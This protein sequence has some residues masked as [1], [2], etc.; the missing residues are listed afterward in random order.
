MVTS[1]EDAVKFLETAETVDSS[2]QVEVESSQAVEEPP[3]TDEVDTQPEET[4]SEEVD[5]SEES[6]PD[7][8]AEAEAE[9]EDASQSKRSSRRRRQKQ[10]YLAAIEKH[11]ALESDHTELM[12]HAEFFAEE[13]TNLRGQLEA[14]QLQNSRL[15]AKLK[16]YDIAEF[17]SPAEQRAAELEFQLA[18]SQRQEQLR[19]SQASVAQQQRMN[20]EA[21]SVAQSIQAAADANGVDQKEVFRG[22]AATKHLGVTVKEA[23]ERIATIAG[24]KV[25]RAKAEA[26]VKKSGS[27]P[28]GAP[29]GRASMSGYGSSLGPDG[30][31]N[32]ERMLED[33]DKLG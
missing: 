22:W 3:E 5:P 19:Q 10:Q 9:T 29:S 15:A 26:K 33:L 20:S 21:R 25:K 12:Q 8:E 27:A 31:N 28:N 30:I 6:E 1:V 17:S 16:E 14:V 23:A 11:K 7:P 13:T 32:A 2:P 18:Q 4:D 24:A